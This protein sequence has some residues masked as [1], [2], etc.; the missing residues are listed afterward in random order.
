[1]KGTREREGTGVAR[2]LDSGANG[3]ADG[4]V[5]LMDLP[6]FKLSRGGYFLLLINEKERVREQAHRLSK[7][8]LP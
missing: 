3:V 1:M 4:S 5:C 8:K 6:C 7:P 2:E